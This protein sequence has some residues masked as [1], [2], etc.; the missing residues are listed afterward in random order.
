M[1]GFAG[2]RVVPVGVSAVAVALVLL[3]PGGGQPARSQTASRAAPAG[4]RLTAAPGGSRLTLAFGGDVHF[5]DQVGGLLR[6]PRSSLASL[7]P[8]LATADVAVVNLETAITSRGAPA[9]KTY[10]FRTTP[11]A[12]TALAAAGV[13][14]VTMAN[15]HAVDYGAVGL[16][17]TLAAQRNSRLPVVGIG[18]NADRAYAPA[19]LTVRG[20]RV[21][22]LGASRLNDWTLQNWTA[23]SSRPGLASAVNTTRLAAAVRAARARADLVVVYLHWGTEGHTCP[24]ASQQR[25]ARAL[26]AAGAGIIVGSH[27]HRVQGAGWMGRTFVDYGLGNFIWYN[28]SSAGSSTSGVLTL[29]VRARTVVASSWTP[30]RIGSDGVPRVPGA[31]TGARMLTAWLQARQCTGL[32]AKGPGR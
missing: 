9:P 14:V 22:V 7:R 11:T 15:N 10:H 8:W 24:D 23:T 21:A 29:T 27:A 1:W 18:P 31:A 25:T 20:T 4:S 3:V 17:D 2:R 26:A 5:A 6:R 19:I 16:R 12:L 30:M 32:A 13:D 28:S